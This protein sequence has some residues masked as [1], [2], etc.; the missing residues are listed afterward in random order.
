MFRLSVI[1]VFLLAGLAMVAMADAHDFKVGSL[2]I[3]HPW[4]RATPGGA[5]VAAGYMTITNKGA[6]P[7]RLIGGSLQRAG[8]IELHEMRMEGDV[9]RMRQLPRGLEIKPGQSVKLAPGGYHLM[10]M[11]LKAPL[12]QGERIKGQLTFEKA[13]TIDIEYAVES[14]GAKSSGG[15]E[16]GHQH[17][18]G[19]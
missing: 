2:V 14:I 17:G 10:F 18:Y 12:K 13:G 5:K 11:G 7:D 16:G 19:R 4:A 9:M 6:A 15:Q 8:R 3:D 1:S